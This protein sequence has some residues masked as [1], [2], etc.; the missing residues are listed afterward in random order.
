MVTQT[1]KDK[2]HH[3]VI[4]EARKP[5]L[6][7]PEDVFPSIFE[8]PT[9]LV[10]G[11]HSSLGDFNPYIVTYRD[12]L[13]SFNIYRFSQ[14]ALRIESTCVDV[15]SAIERSFVLANESLTVANAALKTLGVEDMILKCMVCRI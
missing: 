14:S 11:S 1:K 4:R 12:I 5:V 2:V 13:K 7:L 3:I 15:I 9:A 10:Y 6:L 8:V